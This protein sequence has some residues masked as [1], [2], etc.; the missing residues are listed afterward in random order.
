MIAVVVAALGGFGAIG[1]AMI[2]MMVYLMRRVAQLDERN[3][4]L[5]AYCRKLIDHI[6][7]GA[8]PP[9][10]APDDLADLFEGAS[11]A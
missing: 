2:A 8:G 7:R 10:P 11:T 1:A 5:W 3:A 4:L 6:W 9:P